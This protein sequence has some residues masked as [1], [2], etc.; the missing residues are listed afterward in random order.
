MKV[1]VLSALNPQ[2]EVADKAVS[3]EVELILEIPIYI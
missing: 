3:R 2:I 1:V